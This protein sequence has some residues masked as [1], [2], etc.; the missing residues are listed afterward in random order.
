[1]LLAVHEK[2]LNGLKV[3]VHDAGE[4]LLTAMIGASL[5]GY[6]RAYPMIVQLHVVAD[7]EDTTEQILKS[8]RTSQQANVSIDQREDTID[9]TQ[10][11][12]PSLISMKG[13]QSLT[14]RSLK[15]RKS[16][17]SAKRV[18]FVELKMFTESASASLELAAIAESE[19]KLD[20][21]AATM[22]RGLAHRLTMLTS[23]ISS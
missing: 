11:Q 6:N 7:V 3:S 16:L 12:L 2:N 19:N 23:N 9:L 4:S 15:V 13:R 17:L 8:R 5:E 18:C 22:F 10:N 1:M 20:S 21:A 14:A